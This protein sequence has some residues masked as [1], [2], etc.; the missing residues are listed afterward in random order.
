MSPDS[1]KALTGIFDAAIEAAD[2]Y[3]ALLRSVKIDGTRMTVPGAIYDLDAFERIVVVGAGKAS[4][5]MALALEKILG[6]EI[7]DGLILVKEGHR[8]KLDFIEQIEAS[9]PI[10]NEAGENGARRILEMARAADEKTLLLCLF[11]GGASALL[12]APAQG[13][14]LEDKRRAT[15]L[16]LRCGASIDETNAV[17]KHLSS[18]KGGRLAQEAYPAQVLSLIVS[19][20]VGNRLDVI[21][22]GPTARDGTTFLDAWHV[23][24][25]YALNMPSRIMDHLELGMQGKIDETLKNGPCLDLIRNVIIAD[26]GLALSAA[27]ERSMQL[28]FDAEIVCN[29]LQGEARDAARFLSEIVRSKM[30]RHEPGSKMCL[31]CG[32]ETTVTVHGSGMGGRNQELALAFALETEG[33]DGIAMLSAGTDGGDGPLDAAGAMVDG[34][35]I[36]LARGLGMNPERYLDSNDSYGF[37]SRFDLLSEGRSHFRTG[38]TGTN[39]M[40]IQIMLLG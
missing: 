16:L 32:G 13:V 33:M 24:H 3:E 36:P 12:S 11:S 5:R 8:E 14:T 2:P 34:N 30:A 7:A 10:P 39:V 35:T 29:N 26:I 9:H 20:V 15:S 31:L 23:V 38:P 4:A 6:P 17:R 18:V 21:A 37:F 1:E 27:K 22:S 19:D 28:G 25:K 40:D